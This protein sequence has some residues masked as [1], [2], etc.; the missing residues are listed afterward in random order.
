LADTAAHVTIL[1]RVQGVNF[2]YYTVRKARELGVTGWVRNLHDGR[3]EATFEGDESSVREVVDWCHHGPP[4][5]RVIEV[6]VE[7]EPPT[8]SYKEFDV[9]W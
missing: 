6:T 4:S 9:R 8:G 5:A 1:G 2:R 7:W 3:V